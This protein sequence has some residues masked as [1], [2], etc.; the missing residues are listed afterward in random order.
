MKLINVNTIRGFSVFVNLDFISE[1]SGCVQKGCCVIMNNGNVYHVCDQ[2]VDL[3]LNEI[4]K[5]DEKAESPKSIDI[6]DKSLDNFVEKLTPEQYLNFQERMQDLRERA[7][8]LRKNIMDDID[9]N[10]DE[11]MH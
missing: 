6:N 5:R 9:N 7:M 1:I 8:S 3:L 4:K 10:R 2:E 11:G